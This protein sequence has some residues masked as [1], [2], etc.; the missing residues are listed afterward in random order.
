MDSYSTNT[1]LMWVI[2]ALV[3][4]MIFGLLGWIIVINN[5]VNKIR[6]GSKY[7]QNPRPQTRQDYSDYESNYSDSRSQKKYP[8]KG[9]YSPA[10]SQRDNLNLE[11]DD[12]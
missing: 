1:T 7:R 5:K 9:G 10:H 12:F 2:A 3:I 6:K 11:D 4:I 8:V